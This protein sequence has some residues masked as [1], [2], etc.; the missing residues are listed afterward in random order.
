MM[1]IY[2]TFTKYNR[3]VVKGLKFNHH[4]VAVINCESRDEGMRIIER[5]FGGDYRFDY[6]EAEFEI[7][8]DA[9]LRYCSRDLLTVPADV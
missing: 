3:H 1:K 2:V 6:T 8:G 9:L 5:A 7:N 4:C